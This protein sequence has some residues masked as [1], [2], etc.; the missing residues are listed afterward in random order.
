MVGA[1]TFPGNPYDGHPLAA[2]IRH[3]TTLLDNI[4]TK[5]TKAVVDL[6][7]RGADDDVP[8]VNV[9]HRGKAKRLIARQKARL[10]RH[11]AVEPAIAHLKTDY[12]MDRCWLKGSEGD[13]MHAVLC[14]A[15]FNIR[16]LTSAIAAQPAKAA[17]ALLMVLFW[18]WS[19]LQ[20]ALS[21]YRAESKPAI[22]P[23]TQITRDLGIRVYGSH[24]HTLRANG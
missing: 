4:G 2:Q 5:P 12:R 22:K 13:A 21:G 3:T 23:E 24:Q 1:R 10:R 19:C 16:W 18:L 20:A 14:A 15:G 17:E 6:G 8:T 7:Y 11:Q 9:I